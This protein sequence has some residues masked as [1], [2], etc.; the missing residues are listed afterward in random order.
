MMLCVY[1]NPCW[2]K[3]SDQ[4][5]G[6]HVHSGTDSALQLHFPAN[7]PHNKRPFYPHTTNLQSQKMEIDSTKSNQFSLKLELSTISGDIYGVKSGDL[8]QSECVCRYFDW[9]AQR[10]KMLNCEPSSGVFEL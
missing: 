5:Q 10:F 1:D 6:R 7:L 3:S 4:D 9:V 2:D 8:P